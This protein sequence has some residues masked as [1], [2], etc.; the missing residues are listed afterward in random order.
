M[1]E[2]SG[3]VFQFIVPRSSFIVSTVLLFPAAMLRYLSCS[4]HN[5]LPEVVVF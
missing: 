4:T 3:H 2:K 1:N 5:L